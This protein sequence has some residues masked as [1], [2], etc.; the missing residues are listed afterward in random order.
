MLKSYINSISYNSKLSP[1][2]PWSFFGDGQCDFEVIRNSADLEI[3]K[4]YISYCK[5]Q[6]CLAEKYLKENVK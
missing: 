1:N 6:I 3:V 4:N 5:D 2:D